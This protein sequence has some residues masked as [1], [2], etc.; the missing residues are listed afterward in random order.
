MQILISSNPENLKS[1]N[2]DITIE[3]EY[4]KILVKGSV[5]TLAHHGERSFNP[6]PCVGD[7]LKLEN[8]NNMTIGI[9]HIDLDT[10]GGIMRVTDCKPQQDWFWELA[11]LIDVNGIHKLSKFSQ[12]YNSIEVDR[13]NAFWCWSESSRFCAPRDGSVVDCTDFVNIAI[14][15]I[16]DILNGDKELIKAGISWAKDKIKLDQESFIEQIGDVIVRKSEQFVNHLY[17]DAKAI[18]SFNLRTYGITISLA[19]PIEG[20]SCCQVAQEV[21]GPEAGGHTGIAG[22]PRG[23]EYTLEAALET[24]KA[25]ASLLDGSC[26]VSWAFGLSAGKPPVNRRFFKTNQFDIK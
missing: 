25:L 21:W 13:L 8:I 15:I 24:A 1:A 14:K 20:V 5:L 16:Y 10:I 22:T 26:V 19:D 6:P 3:A 23:K 18:V 11:G 4:G 17:R 9:S 7:N 2:P 12:S